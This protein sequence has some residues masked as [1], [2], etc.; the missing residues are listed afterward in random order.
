MSLATEGKVKKGRPLQISP[1][2]ETC[3]GAMPKAQAGSGAG[4]VGL[5]LRSQQKKG[6]TQPVG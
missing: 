4:E 2:E 1:K 3:A 6:A 5:G